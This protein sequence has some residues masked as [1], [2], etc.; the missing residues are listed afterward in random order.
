MNLK[1]DDN[2]LANPLFCPACHQTWA[3]HKNVQIDATLWQRI[4]PT[5]MNHAPVPYESLRRA[6]KLNA[7]H[8]DLLNMYDGGNRRTFTVEEWLKRIE[9]E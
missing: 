8:A 7:R 6:L 9:H 4:C 2:Q 5:D 3:A 1:Y